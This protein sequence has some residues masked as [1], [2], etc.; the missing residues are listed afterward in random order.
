MHMLKWDHQPN[1]RT[2]SWT[3]SIKAQRLELDGVIEDNP[4]LKP[5]IGEAITRAY[6]K[7][8]V[9]AARETG[10]DEDQFPARCPYD[11]DAIVSREFPT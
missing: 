9:E 5:R 7:T 2:R 3:L 10:L 1:L 11:W 8:C 4:G 6:R